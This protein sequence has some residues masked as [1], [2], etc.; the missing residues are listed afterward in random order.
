VQQVVSGK[1]LRT[2]FTVFFR[3]WAYK[4]AAK[5]LKFI[6]NFAEGLAGAIHGIPGEHL[7]A[8]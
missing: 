1:K 2:K 6:L 4:L 5:L 8:A 7:K 3:V